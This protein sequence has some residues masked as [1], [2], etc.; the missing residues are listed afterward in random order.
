MRQHRLGRRPSGRLKQMVQT[1]V[2]DHTNSYGRGLCFLVDEIA[3]AGRP[4]ERIK[5]WGTLHFL[6]IG[7][8]F[9]CTEP[10]CHLPIHGRGLCRISES[11]RCQLNLLQEVHVEFMGI[12][13][14]L[15]E[16]V[17]H[18]DFTGRSP[19]LDF[20]DIDAR[21]ALGRTALMRAAI[22]GHRSMVEMLLEAGA[23]L[24]SGITTA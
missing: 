1:V 21:D 15:H 9:C 6:P 10:S 3:T 23:V 20:Y 14:V 16:G 11:V 5:V 24:R 4:L 8:P 22:R 17:L 13:S 2:N 19:R 12:A 7:S 18:D